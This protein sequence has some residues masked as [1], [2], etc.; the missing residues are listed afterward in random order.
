MTLVQWY[1]VQILDIIIIFLQFFDLFCRLFKN[2]ISY[3]HCFD[4]YKQNKKKMIQIGQA[5][6][7]YILKKKKRLRFI[8]CIDYLF[9]IIFIMFFMLFAYN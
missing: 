4:N 1:R 8:L 9:H 7:E 3:K 6:F 2:F 5:L